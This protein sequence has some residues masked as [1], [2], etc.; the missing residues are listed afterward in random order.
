MR[1]LKDLEVS[2]KRIF[3]RA[4]LDV[5]IS[6]SEL[7][8]NVR[9]RN[10]LPSVDYLLENGAKQVIVAGH[11]GRPSPAAST[12]AKALADKSDGKPPNYDPNLSTKNLVE[13]LERILGRS[14][15]FKDD[16]EFDE[17]ESLKSL[18][19]LLLLENLRFWPGEEANDAEFAKKLAD[20][21]DCFVNDAFAVCHRAHASMV[22]VPKL[23]PHA[24]GLH[25]QEE[26]ETLSKLLAQ[27]EKPFVAIVGGA[28]IET[29][30]PLIENLSRVADK[31]LVGGYL[32]VEIE[33]DNVELP[34]NVLVATLGADKKDIDEVSVKKFSDVIAQAKTA[35]WN[36]PM[37]LYEDGFEK[38]TVAVAEALIEY[39][40][41]SVVGGGETSDFLASKKLLDSFSFVSSGGGAMLEF[42]SGK[43]LPAIAALE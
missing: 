40:K 30:I 14:V 8:K 3:L 6:N 41:Y 31:V 21:A 18:T 23:L 11:I 37:G 39:A 10:L 16:L 27:P 32:P 17:P 26:V 42:L 15:V 36:G 38:G 22:G 19:Q 2:G 28:K 43:T 9:L 1:L 34:K 4:D 35:V 5:D 33:K 12:D 24:A 20:L 25:L 29:K 13:P 7:N